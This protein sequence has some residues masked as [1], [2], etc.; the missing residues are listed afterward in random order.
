MKIVDRIRKKIVDQVLTQEEIDQVLENEK[1]YP[2]EN[3]DDEEEDILKYTNNRSQIWVKYLASDG[4]Y[5]VSDV[6]MKTK[7]RGKT[8]VHAFRKVEEIRGMMDYFRDRFMHDEFLV[9]MLGLLLARRIG[10]I[11]SLKW[12]DFYD[13]NGRRKEIINTLIEQK[14]DKII[15]ITITDITWKYIDRYCELK[16]IN[17]MEHFNEDIF[18]SLSDITLSKNYTEDEYMNVIRKRSS[19]FRY[20]FKKAADYNGI[21]NVSTHSMRKTFGYIS[22]QI[23]QFD[24]DCLPT[25]QTVLGHSDL[26]TT[27][28][29]IDI[30]NEKAKKMFNDVAQYIHDV[31]NGVTPAIDNMPVIALK[32][33]DL[34][35]ILI[36]AYN[37]G[38]ESRCNQTENGMEIMNE[39][40]FMVEKLRVS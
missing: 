2:N 3:D 28:R 13:E 25:L 10:D 7:K 21:K 23:N 17:P 18:L 34:R 15:D 27:K 20:E 36:L 26:E 16:N 19:S 40:L 4:E 29:Y 31:D 5:Y 35:D 6:T 39:L 9:F 32:T 8:T 24:P 12:S 37:K 38:N 22:H 14:T 30:M 1:Y 11:V 33:N